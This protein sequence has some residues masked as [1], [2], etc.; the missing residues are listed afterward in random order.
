VQE[1]NRS[2]ADLIGVDWEP[3]GEFVVVVGYDIVWHAGIIAQFD[4]TKLTS[5]EFENK[6]VYPVAVL[7]RLCGCLHGC[8]ST[9]KLNGVRKLVKGRKTKYNL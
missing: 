2:Q 7:R 5:L 6:R 3:N 1:V 9:W 4:G 8:S